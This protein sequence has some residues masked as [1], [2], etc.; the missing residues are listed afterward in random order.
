M[1]AA[2][3]RR[4]GAWFAAVLAGFMAVTAQAAPQQRLRALDLSPHAV[5]IAALP[6][7]RAAEIRALVE[8]R[9]IAGI[10]EAMAAG[11]LTAVD[12]ATFHLARIAAQDDHLRAFIEINPAALDE[13]RA[14][15]A[16]RAAG[17][18]L[19]PLHGIAVSVKDNIEAAG[20]MRTT[21]NAAVLLDNV[22]A[23]DAAV[24]ARLRAGGAVIL[25]KASL[26]EFAGV[27][28]FGAG[29]G[30]AGAV[31]GQAV[32]PHGAFPVYGSSAGSAVGT[33]AL[34]A[35]VS[36]GTETSGS[37]I[38]PAGV[39]GVVALKPTKGLVSTAG[40]IPLIGMNDTAGPVA[41]S[42]ADAAA[43][44]SVI[45]EADVDYTAA[46]SP[47]ALDGAVI[48]VPTTHLARAA[49]FAPPMTD[50]YA[51]LTALGARLRPVDLADPSGDLGASV[52]A[53][54]SGLRHETIPYVAARQPA[55]ATPEDLI[56][57]NAADP[58]R[59]APFGM[60]LLQPLAEV[61]RAVPAEAHAQ[62][63]GEI[64]AA[65]TTALEEAFASVSA[66]ALLS[67]HSV[68]APL[69]AAAGWS[70]I[71]VPMGRR[72]DGAPA[73]V[74]LIARRGE[75]A[76]LLGFAYALEQATRARPAP[77]EPGR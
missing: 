42:V 71:T 38:A 24:V 30:G 74:T 68:H 67:V 33:A 77:P 28:T 63:V 7:E 19:G 12:L 44:L 56:A 1:A 70:A 50:V 59:R 58:A 36:I 32:N 66:D 69:Y 49:A 72:P 27:V 62:I 5:A 75:D 41:R 48:A 61:G 60:E 54:G 11:H 73:G 25:G 47:I 14:A 35:T 9:G 57:W 16:A 3:R 21:A 8:G 64:A 15:D 55:I 52:V 20:P 76:R 23:A 22:A 6:P 26:S 17:R 37:L 18:I 43:L 45:D 10:E 46:L 4:H 51:I 34:L 31:A 13:A 29:E 65:A 53:L 40:I 39:A 2:A